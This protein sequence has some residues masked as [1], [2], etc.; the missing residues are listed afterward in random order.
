[1]TKVYDI[2]G[3]V[4]EEIELPLLFST[5]VREDVIKRAVLAIQANGRQ[6]YGTDPLAGKRSSAHYHASRHYRFTM[7]NKELARIS[8]IHGKVG[9]LNLR[10]RVVPQAVKGR[11]AHPPKAEKIWSQKINEKERLLAIKS[12]LAAATVIELVRKRGHKADE[13]PI[14]FTDDFENISRSKDARA[15]LEKIMNKELERCSEKKI[16]AGKGKMRGRKYVTKKGPLI[17]V[18]KKCGIMKAAQ[19]ITGVDIVQVS[20]LNAELLAPGTHVGRLAIFTKSSLA[21]LE[22]KFA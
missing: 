20:Q 21:E 5:P 22:K 13:V 9:Y 11:K 7:M 4:V 8:R 16:R 18:S 10:A 17:I 1:M 12:A 6:P 14:I 19:N 2:S 3:K 15:L